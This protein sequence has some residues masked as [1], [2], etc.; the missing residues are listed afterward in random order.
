MIKLCPQ[1]WT[2]LYRNDQILK[3]EKP[4]NLAEY[5]SIG[6]NIL[7]KE[8]K[9]ADC[10]KSSIHVV[11]SALFEGEESLTMPVERNGAVTVCPAAMH[12][13]LVD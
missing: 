2:A 7:K 13:V 8:S 9:I 12:V 6:Q 10:K 4:Q 1:T 11:K 3:R 5:K